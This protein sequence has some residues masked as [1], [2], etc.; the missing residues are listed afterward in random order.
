MYYLCRSRMVRIV[1][2]VTSIF[3]KGETLLLY[4]MRDSY[5]APSLLMSI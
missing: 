5:M 2:P 4:N 1:L 3:V